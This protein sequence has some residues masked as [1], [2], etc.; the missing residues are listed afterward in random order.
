MSENASENESSR[1]WNDGPIH[2]STQK[3]RLPIEVLQEF[4]QL[5]TLPEIRSL[6]KLIFHLASTDSS[7]SIEKTTLLQN[8]LIKLIEAAWLLNTSGEEKNNLSNPNRL[9]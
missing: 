8:Q 4:F 9:K 6:V 2:I 5:Y 7:I 3:M 1:A